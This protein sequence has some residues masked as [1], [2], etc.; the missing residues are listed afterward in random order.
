M[1]ETLHEERM[2][3]FEKRYKI[4]VKEGLVPKPVSAKKEKKVV[5]KKTTP[6]KKAAK[7]VASKEKKSMECELCIFSSLGLS[8]DLGFS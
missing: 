4:A 6:P 2:K 7:K 1:A 3:D 5:T 8:W